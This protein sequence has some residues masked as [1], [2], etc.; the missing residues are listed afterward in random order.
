MFHVTS[1]V[2]RESI[3]TYGLDW[4]RMGNPGI[5]GSTR[6]EFPGI[7]LCK[8]LDEVRFFVHISKVATDSWAA[9][10]SGMWIENGPSGWWIVPEIVPADRVRLVAI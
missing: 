1:T 8:S 5:A 6:P 10:V 2:N 4:Q 9:D 7:F 3:L